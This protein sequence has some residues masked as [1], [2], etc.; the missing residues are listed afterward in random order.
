MHVGLETV[1]AE[2]LLPVW[3]IPIT[4]AHLET[5]VYVARNGD[6]HVVAPYHGIGIGIRA[7][8]N[9]RICANSERVYGSDSVAGKGKRIRKIELPLLQL[10]LLGRGRS[11]EHTSEL[12]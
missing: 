11:E 10:S 2:V 8:M 7:R 3:F 1:E 6:I 12:Q 5:L 4:Y 9:D